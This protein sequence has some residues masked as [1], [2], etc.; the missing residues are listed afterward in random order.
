MP[1]ENTRQIVRE[2]LLKTESREIKWVNTFENSD[3]LIFRYVKKITTKKSLTFT[4]TSNRTKSHSDLTI[5]FGPIG[6][7]K[8]DTLL[9]IITPLN[10][11]LLYDLIDNLNKKYNQGD[12]FFLRESMSFGE[13]DKDR[14]DKLKSLRLIN[15]ITKDTVSGKLS[16]ENTFKDKSTSTFITNVALTKLKKL[17]ISLKVSEQSEIK[18][19]NILRVLLKKEN[20]RGPVT[21]DTTVIKSVTLKDFPALI[22]LIKKLYKTF[23]QKEFESPF[24]IEKPNILNTKGYKSIVVVAE[25][26][27][28]YRKH[29]LD[30]IKDIIRELPNS[31]SWEEKFTLVYDCYEGVKKAKTMKEINQLLLRATEVV[32]NNPIGTPRWAR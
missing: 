15:Q 30:S 25:D 26:L 16:W 2:L 13:P 28:E 18:E 3:K 7:N 1:I 8:I 10:Q 17:V 29:I 22:I 5:T 24:I 31:T 12:I 4:V 19:D 9:K 23:L 27:E 21:S 11:P 32:K 6:D 14:S 20:P